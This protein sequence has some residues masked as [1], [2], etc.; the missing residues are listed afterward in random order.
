MP[1]ASTSPACAH[2]QQLTSGP[3]PASPKATARPSPPA[4]DQA[5]GP[6]H[7]LQALLLLLACKHSHH[8][9]ALSPTVTSCCCWPHLALPPAVPGAN[10]AGDQLP[11][12]LAHSTT[13]PHHRAA[14]PCC[15]LRTCVQPAAEP[16]AARTKSLCSRPRPSR[17][18]HLLAKSKAGTAASLT[19]A[20]RPYAPRQCRP[21]TPG[22]AAKRTLALLPTPPRH[23]R[24]MC[25]FDRNLTHILSSFDSTFFPNLDNFPE[26]V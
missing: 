4:P 20:V 18:Q 17:Y 10:P 5:S 6:P 7:R 8:P 26:F 21:Y 2:L 25:C 23:C 22:T 13:E 12:A 9:P 24:C 15:C 3:P 16:S 19:M 1:H 14:H 11:P